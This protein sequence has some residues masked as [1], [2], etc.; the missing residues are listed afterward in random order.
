MV[1]QICHE[2]TYFYTSTF[3]EECHK[4]KDRITVGCYSFNSYA[5]DNAC[6]FRSPIL[7]NLDVLV[8]EPPLNWSTLMPTCLSKG[9]TDRPMAT[10]SE[11]KVFTFTVMVYSI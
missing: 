11:G 7:H 2:V 3:C 4:Y 6:G 1:K 5:S 10:R 9:E 8:N